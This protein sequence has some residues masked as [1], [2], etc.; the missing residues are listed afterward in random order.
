MSRPDLSL[1]FPAAE[2][3]SSPLNGL[4]AAALNGPAATWPS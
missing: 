4:S 2:P 1:L 3:A